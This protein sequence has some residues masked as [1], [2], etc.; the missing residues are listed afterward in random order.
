MWL[1]A[2]NRKRARSCARFKY[3]RGAQ[4]TL[5]FFFGSSE[6]YTQLP[7]LPF[8]GSVQH[9]SADRELRGY[10]LYS[11]GSAMFKGCS[12]IWRRRV[13]IR[14]DILILPV[15]ATEGPHHLLTYRAKCRLR[16]ARL[17]AAGRRYQCRFYA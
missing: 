12:S 10:D 17:G 11:R 4:P 6:N 5:F 13:M 7:T 8:L 1:E 16:F 2:V 9:L 3:P 14:W 15:I